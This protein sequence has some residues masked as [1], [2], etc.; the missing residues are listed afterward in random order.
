M[1]DNMLVVRMN[2]HSLWWISCKVSHFAGFGRPYINSRNTCDFFMF[3]TIL[4]QCHVMCVTC[5][6]WNFCKHI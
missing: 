3:L 2:T 6:F 4:N 1:I 5:A